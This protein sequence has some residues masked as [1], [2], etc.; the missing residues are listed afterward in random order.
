MVF[1]VIIPIFILLALGYLAVKLNVLAKAQVEVIGSFVI[2]IALPALMFQ[3][4]AS[5]DFS[6]IWLPD[7]FFGVRSRGLFL[8][9]LRVLS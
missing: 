5:K 3:S 4:L 1:E 7:F 8:L 6:E 9:W 2:K